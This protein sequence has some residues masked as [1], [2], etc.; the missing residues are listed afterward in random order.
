[1]AALSWFVTNSIL[2]SVHQEMSETSPGADA[3]SSPN[4][5]WTVGV[6]AAGN[7]AKA[8]AGS[9]VNGTFA[10]TPV[11]PDGSITT[12]ANAGDC[13]RSTNK[14]SGTFDTGNWTFQMAVIAVTTGGDQD[15]NA[16]F[17]LFRSANADGSGAT[18]ITTGRLVGGA[19]TNLAT[20]AQQASVHNSTSIGSFSVTD[21]YLFVQVGWEI[22]GPGGK[23]TRDVIH[24][25]GTTASLVTSPNFTPALAKGW[26]VPT[27]QPYPGHV[28]VVGY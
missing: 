6:V 27:E 17:R 22:V 14:Y 8:D 9:E 2:D 3:T 13:W 11:E 12:T 4:Y 10:T 23:T 28:S 24:R 25:V 26:D 1:M 5:G 7:Y 16:G 21:E 18:E 20:S 19:V 15:G